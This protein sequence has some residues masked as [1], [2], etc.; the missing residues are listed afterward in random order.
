MDEASMFKLLPSF[1]LGRL[2]LGIVQRGLSERKSDSV[3]DIMELGGF[4][5][6][7]ILLSDLDIAVPQKL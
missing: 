5:V 3:D 1:A 4:E 7:V 6:C 2:F